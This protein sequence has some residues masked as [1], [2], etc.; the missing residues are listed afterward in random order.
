MSTSAI[1]HAAEGDDS[2]NAIVD[3]HTVDVQVMTTAPS[4][5]PTTHLLQPTSASSAPHQLLQETA[6]PAPIQKEHLVSC[7]SSSTA[8]QHPHPE[9][10]QQEPTETETESDT[11]YTSTASVTER[12]LHPVSGR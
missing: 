11:T 4:T 9:L 3:A 5:F 7:A 6:S 1:V 12:N 2:P 8:H 10:L